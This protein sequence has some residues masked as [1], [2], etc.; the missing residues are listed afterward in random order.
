MTPKFIHLSQDQRYQIEA[1]NTAGHSQTYIAVYLSV[2]K[3]TIS[4]EI[5][6]NSTQTA[7]QPDKYNAAQ[8]QHF[9][10]KRAF[11]PDVER[12]LIRLLKHDWSP[13]QVA[14]VCAQSGLQMPSTEGIYLWIYE[15]KRNPVDYT[16][17]LR[18]HHRMRRKRSLK[19]QPRSIIKNRISIHD[20]PPEVEEQQRS[21]DMETDF[22][23]VSKRLLAHYYLAKITNKEALTIQMAMIATLLPIKKASKPSP[24]TMEQSLLTIRQLVT[25]CGSHG[26][27][28]T[29][30][31]HNKEGVMRIKIS[32]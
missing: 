25:L 2:H 14:L 30:T 6:R 19:N 7:K 22:G 13:E 24:A 26:S 28:Q 17:Y 31:A 11:K 5:S 21:G 32:S 20:R 18:R 3:S 27:L 8:A 29:H 16:S 12:R 9:A 1:L 10:V 23:E 15:Q 4:R